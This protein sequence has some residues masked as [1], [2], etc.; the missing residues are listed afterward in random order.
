[1]NLEQRLI[2]TSEEIDRRFQV[3]KKINA[4][5]PAGRAL[6]IAYYADHVVEWFNDFAWT[7]DPR[8]ISLV[9]PELGQLP[10]YLPMRLVDVQCE[11]LEWF[12]WL[13]ERGDDGWLPKSRGVGASYLATGYEVHQW[14]FEKG[15][16]GTIISNTEEGVDKRSDPDS[17]FEK[18]RIMIEHLPKWMRPDGFEIGLMSSHDNH[19]RLLNPETGAT[20]VGKI[21]PNP[22]R[23]GRSS[24]A[25][26][27]EAA[28]I[29][30]LTGVRRAMR[31]NTNCYVEISTYNGTAEPF[32][33]SA[34]KGGPR[35][36]LVIWS[37]I[38]WYDDEWYQRKKEQY[39]DDPAGF[40]QEIEA[41]P[42]ASIQDIVIPP[43]WVRAAVK[44]EA[45]L[46]SENIPTRMGM[47][48]RTGG[49][50]VAG[51]GSNLSIYR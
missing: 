1:M 32:Y 45:W 29:T 46:V 7:Y 40:A 26:A 2:A 49:L 19:R 8:N 35:V 16:A 42:A 20:I 50:D 10:V 44:F 12:D 47:G 23:G 22:G 41:N 36:F 15:F 17:L 9:H 21:G 28:H 37:D 18:A 33:H 43:T 38:P 14:L 48:M 24:F 13:R 39:A 25:F 34:S 51:Y 4:G 27:D 5:G 11:I 3:I 31:D 30:N 6:A